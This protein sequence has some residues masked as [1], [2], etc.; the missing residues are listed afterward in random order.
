MEGGGAETS[1]G[2]Q[3]RLMFR[4]I[5][6][7]PLPGMIVGGGRAWV[8]LAGAKYGKQHHRTDC[9][10][11][12]PCASLGRDRHEPATLATVFQ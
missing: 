8:Y 7:Q 6:T 1:G 4:A 9:H 2:G 3:W 12:R 10:L 11:G 5:M